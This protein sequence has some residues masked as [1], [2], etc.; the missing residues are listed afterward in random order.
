MLRLLLLH[1]IVKASLLHHTLKALTKLLIKLNR[2]HVSYHVPKIF[3]NFFHHL[4]KRSV[5]FVTD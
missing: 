3:R 4:R 2:F 5:T 1:S